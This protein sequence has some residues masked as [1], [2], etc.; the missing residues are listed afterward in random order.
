MT[1]VRISKGTNNPI[2]PKYTFFFHFYIFCPSKIPKGIIL[3]DP[4]I[5]FKYAPMQKMKFSGY[6]D[7]GIIK[8]TRSNIAPYTKFIKGP[9]ALHNPVFLLILSRP[10]TTT[11]PGKANL[12]REIKVIGKPKRLI[13]F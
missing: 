9:A 10:K 2:N 1:S 12:P 7:I 8:E 13:C 5:K 11:A 4:N 3:K 6:K